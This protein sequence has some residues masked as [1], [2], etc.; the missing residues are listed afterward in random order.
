MKD[1]SV[2]VYRIFPFVVCIRFL[3]IVVSMLS[4]MIKAVSGTPFSVYDY[5]FNDRLYML[6]FLF[7]Y[8]ALVGIMSCLYQIRDVNHEMNA[9]YITSFVYIITEAVVFVLAW[10]G[11][12]FSENTFVRL[13]VYICKIFPTA[14]LLL[15]IAFVLMGI[16]HHSHDQRKDKLCV[17]TRNLVIYWISSFATQIVINIFFH[18]TTIRK[19]APILFALFSIGVFLYNLV[20]IV[21][22]Y[23]RITE[24]SMEYYIY[25]YNKQRGLV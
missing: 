23:K 21:M 7:T 15:V 9:A 22:V 12:V 14:C 6:C 4:F 10:L 2:S 3:S 5:Q 24:F 17:K 11:D 20:I 19:S 16:T 18:L 1:T 8:I 25:Q 13:F